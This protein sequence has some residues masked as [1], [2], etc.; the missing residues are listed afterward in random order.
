MASLAYDEVHRE[1]GPVLDYEAY[2]RKVDI[3]T[4]EWNLPQ[5]PVIAYYNFKYLKE[6]LNELGMLHS[7][8]AKMDLA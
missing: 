8:D 7:W 5:K 4:K 3:Y 1:W 2:Q 6:A